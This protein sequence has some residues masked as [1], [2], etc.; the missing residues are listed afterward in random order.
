MFEVALFS[1]A[2]LGLDVAELFEGLLE[3][4]GQALAVDRE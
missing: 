4:A 1:P 2:T 3:L